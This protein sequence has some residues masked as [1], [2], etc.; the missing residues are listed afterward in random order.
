VKKVTDQFS[1]YCNVV[2]SLPHESLRM[3]ADIVEL[4]P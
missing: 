2:G 4:P 3:V 1:K